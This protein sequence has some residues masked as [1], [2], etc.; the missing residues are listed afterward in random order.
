MFS[1]YNKNMNFTFRNNR[2][3]CDN[4]QQSFDK[5]S[6]I[7]INCKNDNS[8]SNLKKRTITTQYI[9]IKFQAAHFLVGFLLL[10]VISII[11]SA[12][13]LYIYGGIKNISSSN[14]DYV[15]AVT[16]IVSYL[17][18]FVVE[19]GLT[20]PNI[21]LFFKEFKNWRSYVVGIIV[22]AIFFIF[23]FLYSFIL[24]K[25]G[26]IGTNGNQEALESTIKL[27][28]VM[29]GIIVCLIG[30]VCEEL[31]YR[32]GLFGLANNFNKIV[33]YIVSIIVFGLIH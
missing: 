3:K 15:P 21:R 1:L 8:H 20:I 24:D 19:I 18:V 10:I 27:M 29:M 25:A 2:K 33:A 4:C 11:V 28:P 17:I 14:Y 13:C 6:P 23:D 31:T 12:I 32:V 22:F 30:P 9:G 16:M 5:D 7:C 26:V